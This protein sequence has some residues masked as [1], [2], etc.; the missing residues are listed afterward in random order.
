MISVEQLLTAMQN[1]STTNAALVVH[2]HLALLT[3]IDLLATL[4]ITL[5]AI[6]NYRLAIDSLGSTISTTF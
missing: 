4:L 3:I 5:S 1:Y 2:H 6:G